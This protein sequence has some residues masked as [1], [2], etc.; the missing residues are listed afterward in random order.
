MGR[1]EELPLW[2][3]DFGCRSL[4]GVLLRDSYPYQSL[5]DII[6]IRDFCAQKKDFVQLVKSKLLTLVRDGT[7]PLAAV[8]D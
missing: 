3:G 4:L 5:S 7:S 1:G 6:T 8:I 2:K